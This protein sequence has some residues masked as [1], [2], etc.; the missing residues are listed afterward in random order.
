MLHHSPT[1]PH[2][3]NR[4]CHQSVQL[5][6][7]SNPNPSI[8]K[9]SQDGNLETD[10]WDERCIYLRI[11]HLNQPNVGKYATWIHVGD[12][13]WNVRYSWVS[14]SADC[15]LINIHH[16]LLVWNVMTTARFQ[17]VAVWGPRAILSHGL[18]TNRIWTFYLEANLQ[19]RPT[20]V[21]QVSKS[22]SKDPT[23][24]KDIYV[25]DPK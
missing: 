21:K 8:N 17:T 13:F 20:N 15:M 7:M 14:F 25:H 4:F 3:Y 12:K 22:R 2:D 9:A 24:F 11:Y 6:S 16:L 19:Y 5:G 10:P 18:T 23:R 1:W